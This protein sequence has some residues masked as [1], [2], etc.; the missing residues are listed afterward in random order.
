MAVPISPSTAHPPYIRPGFLW[1][2]ADVYVFDID[3]TL[4]N[5]QDT[6][7]SSAFHQAFRDVLGSE[8]NLNGLPLHGNTDV[9][10]LR[11][12]LEREGL[13]RELIDAR[14]P[15]IVERMCAEVLRN[16]AQLQP[17]LCPS[18]RELISWLTRRGKVLG[19]ASGNLETIG[20][21]KLEAAG[22]RHAFS[23]G[24][25]AWPRESRAEIFSHAMAAVR[26][27]W[28][29]AARVCV[30]GDTPA[31]VHAARA[32]G[33]LVIALATGIHDY[34]ELRACHPDACC[35]SAADLLAAA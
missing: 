13:A 17:Q 8:A 20:W 5:C 21:T 28:G 35:A 33:V 2:R 12:V 18:I 10:I 22:V 26:E 19:V 9:G 30:I 11:A 23:F 27:R 34:L 15:Q 25:F 7:H 16:R 31:D 4:L 3:G 1:N 24:S 29:E 14:M 6:V 32:V